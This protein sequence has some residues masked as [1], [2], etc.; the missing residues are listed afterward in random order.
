ME[1]IWREFAREK[2]QLQYIE[3]FLFLERIFND[4][5]E[6][7]FMR[8][9]L[10]EIQRLPDVLSLADLCRACH[11]SHLD[12]RYYLKSGLIP[13]ETTGKKTRCYLVQKTALLRCIEDYSENP[14]KYKI[15]GIW[16]E[17]QHL[18]TIRKSETIYLPTQD[19]ASD[20]ATEYY[21]NKLADASELICVADLVRITGYRPPTI[22]RW[23]K[24][25]KLIAHAKT[26]RLW[27]AK[28]EA[29]RF[30][31]SFTYN[32]INVKSPQHIAD[33]RAIYDLIHPT[34]E[35]EK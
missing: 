32:D 34:K 5:G 2:L 6:N 29:I 28:A 4:L 21:R 31:T 10:D 8:Y 3:I 11:L 9:D 7:F 27:I 26:A 17:K 33:I 18:N 12:A 30:L 14:E 25:K 20:V 1:R 24:K 19:L 15:P 22:T 23:C 13:Y 35:G 16:R